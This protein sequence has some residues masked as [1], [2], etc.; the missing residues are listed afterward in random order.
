[1]NDLSREEI[2]KI[3]YYAAKLEPLSGKGSKLDICK[4]EILITAFFEPSTRTVTSF[5]TAMHTLGG[6][7]Q[8]FNQETSSMKKGETKKDTVK[9]LEQYCDILAIRDIEPRSVEK[10]ASSVTVPVINAGDGVNEHPTQTLYDMYT[11]RK[12]FG[13]LTNLKIAIIGGLK[14]Y[15]PSNS[16]IIGLNKFE[17]NKIFGICPAG[18]EL[19]NQF[20][21]DSYQEI[22]MNMSQLNMVLEKIKPDVVYVTR[23]KKEYMLPTEDPKNYFYTINKSTMDVLPKNSILLHALPR[24]TELSTD[25]DSDPRVVMFKQIRHSLQVRMAILA[26]F[27]GHKDELERL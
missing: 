18:M 16:L 23:L 22:V 10:Y 8:R 11:I 14:Y 21:N 19:A 26:L 4:G 27:L 12:H 15:R 24:T 13:R 9:T 2:E 3:I 1:M 20:R 7:A 25:V 6:D 5:E 17:G